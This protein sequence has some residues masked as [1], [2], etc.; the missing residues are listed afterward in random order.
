[1]QSFIP[2]EQR[3]A[4]RTALCFSIALAL[5][6]LPLFASANDEG[7]ESDDE[8]KVELE[9]LQ[10]TG[11]LTRYSATKSDTPILETARSV[12][13]ETADQI[14]DKG[15]LD[16]AD[17]YAYT[18]GVIGS[19]FGIA[20]RGDFL[21]VRGLEV[22]QYRD[23]LQALFSSYNNTRAH[24][25]TLE[26]VEI[27]K[28]PASVL[29]GQGSPGGLV[30]VVSKRPT[31]YMDQEILLKL[32]NFDYVEAAADLG[33]VLDDDGQWLYRFIGV[34]RDSDTQIDFVH[35]DGWVI[36]PSITYRP[37]IDTNITLLANFQET[38]SDTASQFLPIAGTLRPAPNGERFDFDNYYGEPGFNRYDTETQSITLL[39]DHVFNEVWSGELTARYTHGEADYRQ[40]WISFTGGDRYIRNADG[41]LYRDGFV[42]RTF[43]QSEANSDQF[44]TDTRVRAKF[45]TGAFDH[46]VLAG[47]QYQDV[48]TDN[49]FS[50]LY[51]LGLDL[52][53][54]QPD[55][56]FGDRFW[57]NAF[58]PQYGSFP[59]Q[60]I[61]DLAFV[62]S[63]EAVTKDYGLY[64]SDQIAIDNW[65]FTAG[66]RADW[67]STRVNGRT[68]KDDAVSFSLGALYRFDSGFAPY[69]SYS[70]SFDPVAGIDTITQ[71]ALKPQRGR[72]YEVGIKYQPDGK[73][74][75][76]TIA[77][78]DIEQSNL[79]NP[80]SAVGTVS[81]QEGVAEIQ[82]IE[83]EAALYVDDFSFE[84]NISHLDTESADGFR[85]ASIPAT[86][87][88][89]WLG[90]RPTEV[91]AGFKMGVGVR[92][93]G[94]NYGGLDT[95]RTPSYTLGDLL[96]GYEFENWDLSV[97]F[98]NITDKKYLSTCLARGDCFVGER[99]S[100]VGTL[101]YRF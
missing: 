79:P 3:S 97:N 88:S 5:G 69:V 90:W 42:P 8:D 20:T 23:S 38:D 67:V 75:Q 17:T 81:Q 60:S 33:G 40:A 6:L 93:V 76:I 29:Y 89:F 46:E 52:S 47:F 62:D 32:G 91:L 94:A 26:Q 2:Q 86:Q 61:F 24:V 98:R 99:R 34:V 27:L 64:L 39:A 37:T 22:P 30:N 66:L 71:E 50:S 92:Y 41:S 13:V 49:D 95:I 36:A 72:Q 44:A 59:D 19:P 100:V 10:V 55:A 28:G 57:I 14:R 12:S 1:M 80:N 101:A 15:A 45:S 43:Y 83:L 4:R 96:I 35:D 68:Q 11:G 65:R 21:A 7:K 85:F 58:D 87:A 48:S 56:I 78:F 51:A 84:G 82:G 74:S 25:Y 16:L 73:Q 54:G 18:A 63:P 9:A 77:A 31:E 70:E 53:T